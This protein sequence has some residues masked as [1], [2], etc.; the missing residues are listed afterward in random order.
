MIFDV[1]DQANPGSSLL[2]GTLSTLIQHGVRISDKDREILL[3]GGRAFCQV[4]TSRFPQLEVIVTPCQ[5]VNDRERLL[6]ILTT[7]RLDANGE[8]QVSESDL[9]W[10]LSVS[11]EKP[12]WAREILRDVG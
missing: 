5:E 4:D 11:R 3:Q 7:P 12:A 6:R 2:R 10:A 8:V 9:Q 1:C